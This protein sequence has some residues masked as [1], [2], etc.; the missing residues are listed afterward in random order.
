MASALPLVPLPPSLPPFLRV[1]LRLLYVCLC[2]TGSHGISSFSLPR[3]RRQRR[4]RP[5]Y[6]VI[7]PPSPSHGSANAGYRVAHIQLT[8]F[9][10]CTPSSNR[11][12]HFRCKIY[13]DHPVS[14]RT[15]GGMGVFFSKRTAPH[16]P[17]SKRKADSPTDR[18]HPS[19]SRPHETAFVPIC[20]A[21]A[22]TERETDEGSHEKLGK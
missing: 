1:T 8:F 4:R 13:L 3:R 22:D 16:R 7:A 15:D 14:W 19:R 9:Y 6:R 17:G 10:H 21:I 5:Q 2:I 11:A 12:L 20:H 18:H